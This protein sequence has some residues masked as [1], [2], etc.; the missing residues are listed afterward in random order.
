MHR[1]RTL[2]AGA[3]ALA[4]LALPA[5]PARAAEGV[6]SVLTTTTDLADIVRT[7]GGEMVS[8]KSLCTGPEDP[9]FLDARPS[10][11]RMAADAELLVIVGMELEV[12]YLPLMLRD[13]SNPRIKPNSPGYLDASARIR[14]LQVP[15]G[16][17]TRAM[18]DVH[19]D[20]NPHYLYDPANAGVVAEDVAHALSALRPAAAKGFDDRAKA[21]RAA[22]SDLLLGAA[23]AGDA[24]GKRTGG[25]LDRFKPY[26]GASIV[27]YH[28]DLP[29]LAK[30]LGLEVAGT[31]EPKPGVPPTA[32]HLADLAE[33]A[34]AAKVKAVC[35]EV[36]QS[37]GQVDA[38]AA[39]IGARSVLLAHQPGAVPDATDLLSMYRRN[40]DVLFAALSAGE[41]AK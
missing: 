29:Y 19:P 14:K 41:A 37:A 25:M 33:R 20:G 18:G 31:L 5:R 28:D 22:L 30:R 23:P 12:G 39:E 40:A 3:A 6:V 16:G 10:F 11:I 15:E 21:F 34:K 35:H 26:K 32:R 9:H 17:V 13:G 24:K 7:V 2:F 38:F 4:L 27:T 1:S 8:V 36:F